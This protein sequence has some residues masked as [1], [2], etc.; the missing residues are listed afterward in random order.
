M[1]G[2]IRTQI[3]LKRDQRTRANRVTSIWNIS[4][5]E[6][7]RRALDNYLETHQPTAVQRRALI[8]RLAGSWANSPNWKGIDPVKY[9]Q[10]IR[11]EKGI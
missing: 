8:E 5:S 10:D 7:M 1:N 6:L 3:S 9:Q 4:L 11:R 2:M